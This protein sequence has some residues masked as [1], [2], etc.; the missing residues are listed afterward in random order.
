MN[1]LQLAYQYVVGGLFFGVSLILCFGRGASIMANRSDSRTLKVCLVGIAGYLL[2][3]VIW[4]VLSS[5]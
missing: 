4:I 1:W 2:F 5:R 3:H